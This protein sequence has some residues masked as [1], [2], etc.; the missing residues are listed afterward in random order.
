MDTKAPEQID[1]VEF[2][3]NLDADALMAR[4]ADLDRQQKSL[5]TL[6][7]AVRSRD[8]HWSKAKTREHASQ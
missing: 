5:G 8:T 3:E 6:L 4:I 1:L 7:K 2:V